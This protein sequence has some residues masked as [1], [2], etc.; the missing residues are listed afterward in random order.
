MADAN[1]QK[2]ADSKKLAAAKEKAP[3]LTQEFVDKHGLD[4]DYLDK[5]ARGEE[6]PPPTVGPEHTVDLHRTPGGWQVTPA[7]VKP[8]DVGKDAISR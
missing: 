3:N 5:V 7:G 2:K 1:P 6:S 8:E 4:D